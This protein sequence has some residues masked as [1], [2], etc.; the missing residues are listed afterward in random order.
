MTQNNMRIVIPSFKRAGRVY[1]ANYFKTAEIIVP[2][3]QAAEYRDFYPDRVIAIPDECDGSIAKKRNW[4]LENISDPDG[5]IVMVDDDVRN[6]GMTER[7]EQMIKLTEDEA[8]AVIE[9]G[10]ILAE[11]F[12]VK[13]WGFNTNEDG[14]NYQQYKPFSL[15]SPVLGPFTAHIRKDC[16]LK[17]D[18]R[19]GSK[20]D[21]DFALQHLH[22]YK[23][24]LRLNKFHY[25]C[26]HGDNPGG[27]VSMRTLEYEVGFARAIMNKWGEKVIKYD[28]NPTKM[29][30]ILNGKVNVPIKGV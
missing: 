6:I 30:A 15:I 27:I 11:E 20:E 29:S 28:L 23:K 2:E 19:M 8:L 5:H 26:D 24:V 25:Y 16:D 14:R 17:Y 18:E 21:Y 12:G 3:N 4:I 1:A 13:L 10:F 7:N 9:R 22:R